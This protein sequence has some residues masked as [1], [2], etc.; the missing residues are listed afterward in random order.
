VSHFNAPPATSNPLRPHRARGG[1][2]AL[3][4][5]VPCAALGLRFDSGFMAMFCH[6]QL[7]RTEKFE[8]VCKDDAFRLETEVGMTAIL[9]LFYTIT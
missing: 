4:K 7:A 1:L 3:D 6:L 5:R 2:K 9:S 8:E